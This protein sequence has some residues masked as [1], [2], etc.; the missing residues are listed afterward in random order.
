MTK[1]CCIC[2]TEKEL[3]LEYFHKDITRPSGFAYTCKDCHNQRS[4]KKYDP[5]YDKL[6]HQLY[7]R[8]NIEKDPD[9][10]KRTNLRRRHRISL[11][12]FNARFAEQGNACKICKTKI[13][14]IAGWPVDHDHACCPSKDKTC[15]KCIRGILCQDC[16]QGLGRFK[17]DPELLLGA[18]KYLEEY[19]Q[20]K[21]KQIN[22]TCGIYSNSS[23][24]SR[25]PKKGS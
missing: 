16:N 7:Y 1:K 15:G 24:E 23:Q 12:D 11:E 25:S 14:P 5:E 8:K 2:K 19:K 13:P 6:R 9:F 21:E 17:D 22:V 18:I 3:S 4:K 10:I 20:S